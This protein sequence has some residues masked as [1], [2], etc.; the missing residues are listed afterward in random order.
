VNEQEIADLS[1]RYQQLYSGAI[2]DVLDRRGYT[3]QIVDGTIQ[4]LSPEMR[5]AGPAFTCKGARANELEPDDWDMRKAFLDSLI[6]G[7]VAVVDSSGDTVAAHWGELMS[8]GARGRGCTGVVIDGG[9]R[10]VALLLALRFP[11]FARYRSPAS[12][13]R[14]WRISGFDHPVRLGT[15]L[16]RPGDWVIGDMDGVVVVPADLVHEVADEV[17]SLAVVESN[18]R[19]ELL[20]GGRFSEVWDRYRVG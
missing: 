13:I 11:T 8:T 1:A 2:G 17:E 12:S 6:P 16:V 5:V 4:A 18:M 9:T 10:D 19:E 20:A 15:V 14:R 7:C 3:N